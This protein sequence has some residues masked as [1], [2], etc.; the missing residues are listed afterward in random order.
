[1][2]LTARPRHKPPSARHLGAPPWQRVSHRL[3]S[4]PAQGVSTLAEQSLEPL[5]ALPRNGL[6]K[7]SANEVLGRASRQRVDYRP[8]EA[9]VQ[10][11]RQACKSNPKPSRR[12]PCKQGANEELW[13]TAGASANSWF[14]YALHLTYPNAL[15]ISSGGDYMTMYGRDDRIPSPPPGCAHLKPEGATPE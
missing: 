3:S 4:D 2:E 13:N 14:L 8:K 7:R 15:P 6:G 12:I 10:G 5:D 11:F 9:Q 1:M